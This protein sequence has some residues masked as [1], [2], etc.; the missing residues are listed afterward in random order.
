[1]AYIKDKTGAELVNDAGQTVVGTQSGLKAQLSQAEL[2]RRN[3]EALREFS[4]TS[5]RYSDAILELTILLI[6]I[7]IFQLVATIQSI[8][9]S[10][11]SK[12]IMS[13]IF[14][15]YILFILYKIFGWFGNKSDKIR[16]VDSDAKKIE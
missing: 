9:G 12:L 15:G 11:Y 13:L 14:L 8:Q 2:L 1:M 7:A 5:E 3:T 4:R 6:L 16:K 10:S